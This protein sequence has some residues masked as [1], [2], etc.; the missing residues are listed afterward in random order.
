[1]LREEL[2]RSWQSYFRV[3][4]G[5]TPDASVQ[6]VPVVILDQFPVPYPPSRIFS[7]GGT[8]AP[9]AAQFTVL[10][11]MN[12]D[13]IGV[14]SVVV[15]EKLIVRAAAAEDFGIAVLPLTTVT[16]GGA[17][18]VND[19]DSSRFGPTAQ[20]FSG[21]QL[22]GTNLVGNAA[23]NSV[24]P[25][26]DALPHELT[27]HWNIGPGFVLAIYGQTVNIALQAYFQGKY[28]GGI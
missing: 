5:D 17:V 18:Q 6:I 19:D 3:K 2:V 28:Y 10:G 27:G 16:G 13:N 26:G 14:G 12:N 21:A 15:V 8:R 1:M 25:Y 7:V 24:V 9:V 11:I 22:L 20:S 23:A 4:G